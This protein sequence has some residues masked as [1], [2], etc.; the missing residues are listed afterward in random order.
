MVG[1]AGN[2]CGHITELLSCVRNNSQKINKFNTE[3][4]RNLVI[5][6][7]YSSASDPK[8]TELCRELGIKKK[9]HS[10]L[11]PKRIRRVPKVTEGTAGADKR[12]FFDILK[13]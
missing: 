7:K 5:K 4:A 11:T 1:A 8:V 10:A 12:P 9:F 2:R 13:S 3:L 6:K